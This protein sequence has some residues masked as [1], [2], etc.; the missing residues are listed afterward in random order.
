MIEAR[1]SIVVP[2]RLEKC[3][4]KKTALVAAIAA[5]YSSCGSS[6]GD[7]QALLCEANTLC[8]VSRC[9]EYT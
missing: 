6:G 9:H 2:S 5:V 3:Y 7:C 1:A 8:K 4:N